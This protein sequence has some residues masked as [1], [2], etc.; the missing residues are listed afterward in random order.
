MSVSSVKDVKLAEQLPGFEEGDVIEIKSVEVVQTAVQGF[1]GVRVSGTD[2]NGTEKAEMLWLRPVVG[3]RS[4]LGAF[5][6]ALGNDIDK[7]VGKKVKIITWRHR[8]RE[9]TVVG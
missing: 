3:S 9:I 4:K 1:R 5:I 2:Q 8:N 6:A 7:W